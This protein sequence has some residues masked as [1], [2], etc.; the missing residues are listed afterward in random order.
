MQTCADVKVICNTGSCPW[1]LKHVSTSYLA[2]QR[3]PERGAVTAV[4]QTPKGPSR[5][6]DMALQLSQPPAPP[7]MFFSGHA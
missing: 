5:A 1:C 4:S 3:I 6:L 7:R 2:S